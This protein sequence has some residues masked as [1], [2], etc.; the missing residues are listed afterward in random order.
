VAGLVPAIHAF[1]RRRQR[2]GCADQVSRCWKLLGYLRANGFKTFIVSGGGVEFMRVFAEKTYGIPPEQVVGSSGV[3]KF[4][5][6]SDGKSVL[7]KE[8]KSS[9][10]T[11]APAS[12]SASVALLGGA[13]S[14]HSAIRTATSRCWNG[15]RRATAPGSWASSITPTPSANMPTTGS[16]LSGAF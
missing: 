5:M 12:R 13:R 16:R 6:Q 15:P 7:I 3:T 8:P 4:E 2:R 10:S 14:W 9:L 11:T 1:G